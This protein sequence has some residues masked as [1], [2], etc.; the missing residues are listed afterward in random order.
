MPVR[1]FDVY[2]RERGLLKE[3]PLAS[4]NGSRIGIDANNYLKRLLSTREPAVSD[5]FLAATGG[6]PLTINAD[7]ERD[8]KI[9]ETV[10]V[11][12]IF[13]FN[14]ITPKEYER[15]FSSDEHKGWRRNQGWDRYENGSLP[16]AQYEFAQSQPTIPQD[17]TR[18]VHRLFKPRAVEFVVAPYLASGQLVY[19]E[20]HERQYVHSMFGSNELFMYEGV[21]KVILDINFVNSTIVFASKAAILADLGLSP[22]QFLD[23]AILTGFEGSPTFPPLASDPHQF[24]FQGAVQLV[25]SRGSGVAAIQQFRDWPPV[26]DY[27]DQFARA[28]CMIKFSL[29][30][31]ANEGRV[32][33]LPLVLPPPAPLNPLPNSTNTTPTS[34]NVITAADIPSDLDNIFSPHLPSEVYYQL[35][36]GLVAPALLNPLASGH[37][38][39]STPLCGGT[40]EYEAFVRQLTERPNS[41]RCVALALTSSVLNSFWAKRP[42]TAYYYFNPNQGTLIPHSAPATLSFIESV[43]KWN[44]DARYVEN[45]LR[46]QSS[47]TIDLSLCLGGTSTTNY[48]QRTI[49]ARNNDKLLEKKDEIVANTLWRFLQLRSFLTASHQHTPHAQALYMAMKASKVNDKFQDAL[50][51]AMELLRMKALHNGKIGQRVYTGGPNFPQGSEEDKQNM[52]L[53]IRVLSIV[54]LSFSPGPWTGPL[55]RELLVFNSFLRATSRAMRNLLEAVALNILLRSDARRSREDY[56]DIALS[57]PFQQDTNTGMGILF[58]A[59]GDTVAAIC[60]GLDVVLKV[61]KGEG[62]SEEK[63]VVKDAKEQT[64]DLLKDAFSNVKNVKLELQRG[65]RFWQLMML[66][67]R[68]LKSVQGAIEPE[69]VAQFEAADSWV[70]AFA[71]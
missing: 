23:V 67:V 15:P 7:I 25:K 47:S 1:G 20:R 60:G 31:V 24:N 54:P 42:V 33:P 36:R 57:L 3:A 8:L 44:V 70:Q 40:A 52:L 32:L 62:T 38:I 5:A 2:L 49:V 53:V 45:E 64:I 56:V 59:F 27:V 16:E 65:L 69:L 22:D 9:L 41:P 4:L 39:E 6:S 14:G 58:K 68:S 21:D 46:R 37:Y 17:V 28:K 61:G 10:K 19:L 13:V 63:A 34:P 26:R 66:A 48:A 50:Y 18:A 43:A 35:F 51:L 55:S 11:K 12:P 29:V 71:V 30:L